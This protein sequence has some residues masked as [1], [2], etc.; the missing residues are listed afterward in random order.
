[1]RIVPRHRRPPAARPARTQFTFPFNLTGEPAVSLPA[2]WTK[3]GLRVGLQIVGDRFAELLLL[4]AARHGATE[5]AAG[6]V[7]NEDRKRRPSG[8]RRADSADLLAR[9]VPNR[10]ALLGVR[11]RQSRLSLVSL[12]A[13]C[14]RVVLA[15]AKS[16][17]GFRMKPF[18]RIELCHGGPDFVRLRARYR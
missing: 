14:Q 1:R 5:A 7:L 15:I 8:R 18:C 2:G 16:V 13:A 17:A 11:P 6:D 4:Q 10:K 9:S 12:S 3:V